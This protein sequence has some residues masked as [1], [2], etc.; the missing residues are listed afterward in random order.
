MQE[1]R[2]TLETHLHVY[3]KHKHLFYHKELNF[4]FWKYLSVLILVQKIILLRSQTRN[5]ELFSLVQTNCKSASFS[6]LWKIAKYSYTLFLKLLLHWYFFLLHECLF[7]R[8]W[9]DC[10]WVF[11]WH[12]DS[13]TWNLMCKYSEDLKCSFH[14]SVATLLSKAI[15]TFLYEKVLIYVYSH[16]F[17]KA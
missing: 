14:Y 17:I 6:L 9:C 4:V 16:T 1:E 15:H 5:S 7:N 11:L 2:W 8:S 10:L 13:C 12:T 3:A